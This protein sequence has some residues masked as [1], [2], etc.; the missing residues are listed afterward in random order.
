MKKIINICF[1]HNNGGLS[2][3]AD[4]IGSLLEKSGYWV[5]YN[6]FPM[7]FRRLS[8]RRLKIANVFASIFLRAL[9]IFKFVGVKPVLLAIHLEQIKKKQV[10]LSRKNIFI[11]NLE[12][13]MDETYNL[14]DSIDMFVCKTKD[15]M[16]FCESKGLTAFYTSFSTISVFNEAY[17]QEINTFVHIAG[18]SHAKGTVPLMEV[19]KRHPE[20]PMLK[21]ISRF[22]EHLNGLAADNISVLG[23]Y[24]DFD[25]LNAIQNS[26]EVHVCTSEAEGFGH[27]ICEPLSCGA[28][29]IT[30]NGYPMNELVH[31]DR[32]VL[33][34][35][36]SSEPMR[37]SQKFLFDKVDLEKKVELVLSMP[38]LE[39]A[40]LKQNA[41]DYYVR[42]NAFF[43]RNMLEAIEKTISL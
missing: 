34:N 42:N 4:I 37:Y 41:K 1:N 5:W 14:F 30:V 7:N 11:A 17:P 33:V 27:Y 39:R 28:I 21:V 40:E 31:P 25:D 35:V 15:A 23:G 9:T 12:W 8:K 10:S 16:R 24:L 13:L 2:L 26:S 6:S 36:K 3:D 19:W 29:V 32:G 18:N 43:E 22:T 38:R 20:W